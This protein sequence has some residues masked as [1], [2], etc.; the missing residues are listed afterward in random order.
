MKQEKSYKKDLIRYRFDSAQ[1]ML[2]DARV[3]K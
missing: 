3:L 1:E 2:Q